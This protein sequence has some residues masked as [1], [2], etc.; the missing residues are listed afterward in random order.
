MLSLC[1]LR[2]YFTIQQLQLQHNI[3]SDFYTFFFKFANKFNGDN[4]FI[5]IKVYKME[6]SSLWKNLWSTVLVLQ[7]INNNNKKIKFKFNKK[8][9]SYIA[10]L[11]CFITI[12]FVKYL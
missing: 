2:K 11:F 7:L 8:K 3:K 1:Q 5:L 12:F 9:S 6:T 4:C 10:K